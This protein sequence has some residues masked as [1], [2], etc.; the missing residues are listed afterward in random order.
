MSFDDIAPWYRTLETIA[1]GDDLQ[2]ARVAW[3]GAIG[4]PRRALIIGEGNGRFLCELLRAHPTIEV[5][6]VDSSR[7]MLE[8]ARQRVERR[9]PA[10]ASRV[11][12]VQSDIA[13]WAAE[14]EYDLIVTH[15]LLDC[16]PGDQ[17]ANVVTTLSQSTAA[18]AV[19]LLAD[20][21]IAATGVRRLHS[22]IWL[23]IMYRF[24]RCTAKIEAREL[25]DPSPFLR[26]AGF[27]LTGQR[28]FRLAMLKSELW[29]RPSLGS[30][31]C[32]PAN[33][34]SPAEMRF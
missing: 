29:Q 28:F 20:F 8:L 25:V 18:D 11:R 30:A 33:L 32:Q 5:D 10:D 12:F 3:L 27:A 14:S 19:W 15:F 26:G 9:S 6:C 13:F 22:R 17:I 2:R 16:F 23:A 34:G 31:G 24:F 4:T 21:C 7:R 1:F